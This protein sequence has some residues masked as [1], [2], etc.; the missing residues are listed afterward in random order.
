MTKED[1][2]E[3]YVICPNCK[4]KAFHS[5]KIVG[6]PKYYRTYYCKKCKSLLYSDN[7]YKKKKNV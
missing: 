1:N 6:T 3:T 2:S 5:S 7:C 4:N